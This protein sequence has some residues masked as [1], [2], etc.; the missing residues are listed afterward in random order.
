MMNLSKIIALIG[1]TFCLVGKSAAQQDVELVNS[2]QIMAEGNFYYALG[3]YSKAANLYKKVGRSDTNYVDILLDL[4][5]AYSAD[6]ED[7]LCLITAKR[8]LAVESTIRGDF[9][10]LAGISLREMKK[11]D[12]AIKMFDDGIAEYPYLYL[13]QYNKGKTYY[14]QKKF[15]EAEKCFQESVRLNEYHATSHYFL[16]KAALDQGRPIAAILSF[17]FYLILTTS[18]ERADKVVTTVEDVYNSNYD[19]DVDYKLDVKEAGDECFIPLQELIA[20]QSAL[21]PSYKNTTGVN[22]NFVKERQAMFEKM[23]YIPNTGNWWMEHYIPFFLEMQKQGHFNS[24]NLWS[25]SSLEN[26]EVRKGWKKNKKKIRAF[27]AWVVKHIRET[28]THPALELVA[29]KENRG[30]I[31]YDNKIIAGVGHTDPI[32]KKPYGEWI[33]FYSRSGYIL[34]KGSYSTQG[35]REGL[36]TYFHENGKVKEKTNYVNDFK[37]G[38]MEVW[39]DNG[40]KRASYQNVKGKNNGAYTIY[41]YHGGVIEKGVYVADKLTG[42]VALY[43]ENDKIRYDFLY[44]NG[45]INGLFKEYDYQGKLILEMNFLAG[46]KN[47]AA[48]EYYADGK[49][50]SEGAYKNDEA[51]GP[52]KIYWDNGKLKRE[53][54]YKDKGKREGLWNEYHYNGNID[55]KV[56]YKSG[57]INGT[58]KSYAETSELIN[59]RTYKAGKLTKSISYDRSGAVLGKFDVIGRTTVRE[60]YPSGILEAEGDYENGERVGL[61]TTYSSNGGWRNS[62]IAYRNGNVDGK[63][64]GYYSNGK[65][66]FEVEYEQGMQHGYAK[67]WHSN[68]QIASEGWFQYDM[69]QGDWFDYNL[70]GIIIAHTFYMNDERYGFQD[71][72][73]QRG[74][75]VEEVKIKRGIDVCRTL[76]D[77]TGTSTYEF[78]TPAGSGKFEPMFDNGIKWH[79]GEYYRGVRSGKYSTHKWQGQT[80]SETNY[81]LGN[82]EGVA[83]VYYDWNDQQHSETEKYYGLNH[84]KSIGWWE[85][86]QKKWEEH[87]YLDDLDGEQKYYHDNGQLRKVGTW[88]MGIL[89][90]PLKYYG[91]DGMLAYVLYYTDGNLQGYSYE[92]TDG[93]LLPMKKLDEASGKLECYYRNGKKSIEGEFQNGRMQGHWLEYY[94]DGTVKEDELFSN[95]EREGVQKRFYPDGKPEEVETYYAGEV[96]GE[97]RYYYPNGN[98]KRVEYWTLGEEWAKWSFYNEQGALMVTRQFCGGVQLNENEIPIAM[99]EPDLKKKGIPNS[100]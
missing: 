13:L 78:K 75:I 17:E 20:S 47:G 58:V 54:V 69:K 2:G 63:Y 9:F 12:E 79:E 50:K 68:G 74:R 24:F 65:V 38:L 97:C 41:G 84:G 98:V 6:K 48:K 31:F 15:M 7:S 61:W 32:T 44:L 40:E 51:F 89:Q 82:E 81:I 99:P 19:Y 94:S 71:Y 10:N 27:G 62:T 76:Y 23:E 77:S 42:P 46:K 35:K 67:Y 66:S 43:H 73:N 92:G 22:L 70:R 83:K 53:G 55:A 34:G 59:E 39:Y 85:N 57:L 72:Y 96:D 64:K 95:G 8:G 16:G 28:S 49:V 30:V 60:Y 26:A 5:L 100:K 93:N 1:F 37:E 36:W 87:F 90:G 3:K 56:T 18:D 33:Y 52:W 86:G 91:T 21:K 25:L 11:Y 14:E 29:D 88:V 45:K 4:C 80:L